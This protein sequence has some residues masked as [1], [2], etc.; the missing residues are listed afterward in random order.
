MAKKQ[1]LFH[2][3]FGSPNAYL[4]HLLIPEIEKRTGA[5]FVYVPVLIGGVFKA[6][7][8]NPPLMIYKDVKNKVKYMSQ[9]MARFIERNDLAKRYKWNSHFPVNSLHMMRGAFAAQRLGVYEAYVDAAFAGTWC[10]DIN[11]AEPE[12]AVEYITSKGVDAKP[13]FEMTSEQD[14]KDE[15]FKSTEKAVEMGDFGSPHFYYDGEMYFG[16]DRLRDLEEHL[17]R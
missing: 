17:A 3:D 13:I 12:A 14:I 9:D 2:Y 8:N 4:A 7:G 16:K 15:L 11:M 5:E 1:V 10:D 6:T